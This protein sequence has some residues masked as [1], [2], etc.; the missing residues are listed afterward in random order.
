MRAMATG[1]IAT[2]VYGGFET[3]HFG[4]PDK[5]S[6]AGTTDSLSVFHYPLIWLLL[7]VMFFGA[8]YAI[9][10]VRSHRLR[11]HRVRLS[12]GAVG[13]VLI[14]VF[15]AVP[16]VGRLTDP[17]DLTVP[18]HAPTHPTTSTVVV[19]Y[20]RLSGFC[21]VRVTV[22]SGTTVKFV[23]DNGASVRIDSDFAG[24]TEKASASEFSTTLTQR[25]TFLYTASPS[26][27]SSFRKFFSE[28]RGGT[29]SHQGVIKV[30]KAN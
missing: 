21:P 19:H 17:V 2:V 8:F 30:V 6:I 9:G 20:S 14:L 4:V 13:S 10:V 16:L 23:A 18:C 5:L 29:E 11:G 24:L 12:L 27:G 26:V 1:L 25:G 15:Y 7:S 28:L 3:Y 22:A